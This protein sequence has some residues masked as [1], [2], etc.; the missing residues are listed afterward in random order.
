MALQH[1]AERRRRSERTRRAIAP[2]G[3]HLQAYLVA[4]EA[5]RRLKQSPTPCF[6]REWRPKAGESSVQA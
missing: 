5:M 2:S 4:R 6:A 3:S 1:S